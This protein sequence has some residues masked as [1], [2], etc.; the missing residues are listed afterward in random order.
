MPRSVRTSTTSLAATPRTLVW[1]A[2]LPDFP[3]RPLPGPFEGGERVRGGRAG[4]GSDLDQIL[5]L[6]AAA[7]QQPDH[8][9]VAEV[10]LH[11]LVVG[12]FEAMHAEVRPQQPL[13]G[14]Q[15]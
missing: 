1:L 11:R 9:A 7:A 13:G 3:A 12:P 5:D 14:G 2:G 4:R 10:E 8:V 15:S 6:E